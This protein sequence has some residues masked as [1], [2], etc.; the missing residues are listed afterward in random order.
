MNTYTARLE[1]KTTD[2]GSWSSKKNHESTPGAR[3]STKPSPACRS[4]RHV[5]RDRRE[6]SIDLVPRP[7]LPKAAG[8]TVEQARQARERA[9]VA[10]RLAIEQ[11]RKA[12]VALTGRAI[13]MRDAAAILGISHQR[14]HQLLTPETPQ[15][16]KPAEPTHQFP[17]PKRPSYHPHHHSTLRFPTFSVRIP[18]NWRGFCAIR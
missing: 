1:K 9:R 12:A 3:P 14:V 16:A 17:E 18:P 4:G 15:A 10:D 5:V 6:R 11:T 8:R 7:V 2:A 13:S